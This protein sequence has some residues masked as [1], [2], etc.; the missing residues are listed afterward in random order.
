MKNID[1]NT[2]ATFLKEIKTKIYS[3]FLELFLYS[4]AE[5]IRR[6]VFLLRAKGGKHE[7]ENSCFG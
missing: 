5:S 2:F 3:A 1:S 6:A 4:F 7:Y